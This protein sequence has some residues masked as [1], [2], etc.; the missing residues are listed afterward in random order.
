[1]PT[2]RILLI[3]DDPMISRSLKLSLELQDYAVTICETFAGGLQSARSDQC[4]M[5][6][7]DVNL[8]DG[9]GFKLCREI[10]K[11]DQKLP[12]L[13]L[14]ANVNEE[15]AVQGIEA[16]ADDYIRKPFGLQELSARIK[17]VLGKHTARQL[18]FGDLCVELDKHLAWVD[19]QQ[20]VLGK[21]EFAILAALVARAGHVLTRQEILDAVDQHLAVYDRTIDS[22]L[23][24]LR[25]KLKGAGAIEL[26]VPVY[27]VGYRLEL[28]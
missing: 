27:G 3:E 25:K 24:H 19:D 16:G 8:P 17:R 10:R 22:H 6:L 5:V 14:T 7:L 4:D 21:R 2:A 11:R 18:R 12:V 15:S 26:I 28:T 23:S 9:D 20:L 1:M 13:M